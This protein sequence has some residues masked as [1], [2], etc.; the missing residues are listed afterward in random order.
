MATWPDYACLLVQGYNEQPD[1]GV[2]RTDMDGG[3]AKQRPRWSVPI[4]TRS[5]TIMVQSD[6]DKEAFDDWIDGDINRGTGWFDWVV[7]RTSRTVRARIVR[8]DYQ[9]G[10]PAG[11]LW[12]ATC[13][14]EV[15]G[16]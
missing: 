2:L 16:R 14:I 9:W 12:Q 1:Y 11:Q 3:I 8:G 6:A 5:A 10:E 15:V 13:Q 7:P 4:V